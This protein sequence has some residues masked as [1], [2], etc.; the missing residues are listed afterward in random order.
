MKLDVAP[1]KY[2]VA[3]S[4]GVD[5]MALLDMLTRM[6]HLELVVAYFDH[7]IRAD[8]AEDGR[9]VG[10]AAGRYGLPFVSACGNLGQGVSEAVARDAR[11]TF[12]RKVQAAHRARGI[13]TAHHQDDV[14]ETA[15]LNMLRGTGRR[16]LSSL[17]SGR[18]IIRPLLHVAKQDLQQ[19]A[20]DHQL[21]WREDSTNTNERYLRNYVRRQI[22]PRMHAAQ[23]RDLLARIASAAGLNDAI[24][25]LLAGYITGDTLPRGW[26]IMLPH[27]V[28]C[29][30]MASWLRQH[31]AAFD[32]RAVDRLVVFGKTAHPG[33][34]HDVDAGHRLAVNKQH[35]ILLANLS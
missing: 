8:S 9:V 24:D 6:S 4:G 21:D 11:Y 29:D 3:V 20:A 17:R 2:V 25:T 23:R 31:A 10:T 7:G 32:H 12:L 35:I 16:G 5:S 33:K 14:L 1:G 30:V 22:I 27:M 13:L 15:I 26:F 18:G 34:R 19:Y 28:A